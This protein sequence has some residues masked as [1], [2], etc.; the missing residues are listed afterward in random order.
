MSTRTNPPFPKPRILVLVHVH[1]RRLI[2]FFWIFL[3]DAG[4][5]HLLFLREMCKIDPD[6]GDRRSKTL[7]ELME[8]YGNRK[9]VGTPLLW[10]A[11]QASLYSDNVLKILTEHILP[12]YNFKHYK[13]FVLSVLSAVGDAPVM[14]SDNVIDAPDFEAFFELSFDPKKRREFE[15][16]YPKI[17]VSSNFYESVSCDARFQL[18]MWTFLSS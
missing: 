1:R 12:Y 9:D 10:V 15:D 8:S 14:A 17:R 5:G 2:I 3:G 16:F 7:F 11:A 18:V 13:S 4:W 6:L